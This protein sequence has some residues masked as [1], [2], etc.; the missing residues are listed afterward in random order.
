MHDNLNDTTAPEYLLTDAF[1]STFLYLKMYGFIKRIF[2]ICG[3]GKHL[4]LIK[5]DGFV[6]HKLHQI[7]PLWD[8]TER[9]NWI[10]K[11]E[12]LRLYAE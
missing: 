1:T 2:K 5:F 3:L 12:H 7:S 4:E 8:P 11:I 9:R 10:A 6:F